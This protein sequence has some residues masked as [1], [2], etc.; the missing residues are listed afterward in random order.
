MDRIYRIWE[1]ELQAV[2]DISKLGHR[3]RI[4]HSVLGCGTNLVAVSSAIDDLY[5]NVPTPATTTTVTRTSNN[6]S[7]DKTALARRNGHGVRT[8]MPRTNHGKNR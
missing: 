1:I 2:L 6:P 4:L 5:V 3:K 8:T 7:C